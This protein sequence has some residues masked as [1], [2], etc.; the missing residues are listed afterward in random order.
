[1]RKTNFTDRQKADIY[2][3]DRA[4]CAYSGRNLW[5]LDYGADSRYISDWA[6]HILPVSRGGQS[7][8]ENGICASWIYNYAKGNSERP[9]L[10]LFLAGRPTPDFFY[11][12]DIVTMETARNLK[13]FG[14]LHYS[15]WYFNRALWR[16]CL[17]IWWLDNRARG[18][19]RS[20]DDYYYANASMKFINIWRSIIEK[21]AVPSLKKRGLIPRTLTED[22]KLFLSLRNV[23]S[24]YDILKL[25]K[26]LLPYHRANAK[27]LSVLDKLVDNLPR[28]QLEQLMKQIK[29]DNKVSPRILRC[30]QDNVR[31]LH[32]RM[33]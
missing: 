24:S 31:L 13:R 28:Q 21:E 26:S 7:T 27:A 3:R 2:V 25:M 14:Q 29:N 4:I 8:V 5:L 23:V 17:G 32:S 16:M 12:Y 19:I 1:M 22:Q 9:H 6:D 11:I 33:I 18:I 20:R 30:V 15:D 10:I